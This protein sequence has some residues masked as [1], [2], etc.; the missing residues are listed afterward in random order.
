MLPTLERRR[1]WLLKFKRL[2]LK[3]SDF[4]V[5]C[6]NCVGAMVT[7]D[8]R[9]PLN[10]PTVNLFIPFPDYVTFLE[11][12]RFYLQQEIIDITGRSPYPIG[13]ISGGVK[14]H[15][16][17]YNTFE[18]A[19][20]AWMRRRGRIDF[21]NLYVVLVERDGCT[22]NDLL[23][24]DR[25]PFKHKV[26]IVHKPYTDIK[27]KFYFKGYENDNQVGLITDWKNKLGKRIYDKFDWVGWL[28]CK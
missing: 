3:N 17:H 8:F 2:F 1:E 14:I 16:L 25:L 15:F 10:S 20:S 23:R 19:R 6:N 27:N 24:F 26:A 12:M 18:E 13:E 11:N 4:S 22:H 5:V 28:N 7:H 21:N 9:Q